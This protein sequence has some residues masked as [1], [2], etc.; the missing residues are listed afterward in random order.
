MLRVVYK[1]DDLPPGVVSDWREERGLVEIRVAQEAKP[2]D[3]IPSLNGTLRDFLAN[4]EWFQLWEGEFLSADHPQSPLRVTF[5]PSRLVPTPP[6]YIRE[7]K[8]D[9]ILYVSPTASVEEFVQTLNPSIEE[10]LD[11]G[12]WFQLWRGEIVTMDSPGS[13]AA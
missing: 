5:K 13:A 2:R 1:A 6:V 10:F 12:Q 7:D 4:A 8:G 9:V 3:F 11:G